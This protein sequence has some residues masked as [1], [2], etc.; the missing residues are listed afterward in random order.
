MQ[1]DQK[2]IVGAIILAGALIAG[3]IMLRGSAG[4]IPVGSN[5]DSNNPPQ[6]RAI[7]KDEHILGNPKAKIVIVEYSDLECPFCQRFH[8]V[9]HQVVENNNGDVAWVYRHYPLYQGSEGR[10][11]L[12]P[13]ALKEAEAT[14]CAWEQGGNDAFWRYADKIF[15]ITPSNNGLELTELPN[16]A[17]DIGLDVATFNDCLASGKFKEKIDEDIADGTRGGVQGT[18]SS[19]ILKNGKLVDTIPGALPYEAVIQKL[20]ALK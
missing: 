1:T 9:M 10:P 15:E 12:H 2:P 6:L 18:P 3:A 7:A 19:F 8:D 14:E 5:D 4:T 17:A 13:K 11:P 16:I 20:D